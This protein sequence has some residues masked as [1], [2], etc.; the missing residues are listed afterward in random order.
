MGYSFESMVS[1]TFAPDGFDSSLL[2]SNCSAYKHAA[3]SYSHFHPNTDS[4]NGNT[5]ALHD[6]HTRHRD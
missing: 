3:T 4:K 1:W 5:S 6:H 2:R